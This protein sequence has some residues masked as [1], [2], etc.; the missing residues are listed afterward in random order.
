M[1][2]KQLI[3]KYENDTLEHLLRKLYLEENLNIPQIAER[4]SVSVGWVHKQLNELQ[5]NKQKNIW[6]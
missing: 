2:I 1:S 6:K 5:I 3:E 4:L